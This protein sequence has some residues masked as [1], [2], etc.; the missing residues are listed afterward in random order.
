MSL[1]FFFRQGLFP[2]HSGWGAVA[3]CSFDILGS[4]DSPTSASQVARTTGAPYHNRLIF[5]FLAEMRFCYVEQVGL[6]LLS[7]SDPPV[8]A[9]QSAGIPGVS[10][11]ARC[12]CS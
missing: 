1:Y 10:Y 5:V 12:L 4:S 6:E 9:F 2:C 8:S 11:C 7:S 3:H